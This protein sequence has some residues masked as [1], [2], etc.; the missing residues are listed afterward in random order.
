MRKI[1]LQQ[2][3]TL[4]AAL[5]LIGPMLISRY[6]LKQRFLFYRSARSMCA[7]PKFLDDGASDLERMSEPHLQFNV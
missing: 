4:A 2:G 3:I 5:A 1:L 7:R 6:E